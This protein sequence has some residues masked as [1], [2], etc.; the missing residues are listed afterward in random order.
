MQKVDRRTRTHN[1]L[2]ADVEFLKN[3]QL[4]KEEQITASRNN[5]S[6][7]FDTLFKQLQNDDSA[8]SILYDHNKDVEKI[9]NALMQNNEIR[10]KQ[11]LVVASAGKKAGCSQFTLALANELKQYNKRTIVIDANM[12]SRGFTRFTRM[13]EEGLGLTDLLAGDAPLWKCL[14]RLDDSEVFLL[15]R[16][17]Q[18]NNLTRVLL[19]GHINELLDLFHDLFEFIIVELPPLLSNTSFELWANQGDALIFIDESS[20]QHDVFLKKLQS[21]MKAAGLEFWGKSN[22]PSIEQLEQ[23][24]V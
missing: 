21:Q 9:C 14:V 5:P 17:R 23:E 3:H 7:V 24:A 19:E 6:K 15:E 4:K 2:I 13:Q 10:Q 11:V 16:G 22:V 8:A 12:R 20:K 18:R 1:S